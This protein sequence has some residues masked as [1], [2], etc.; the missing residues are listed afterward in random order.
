M[1]ARA[2]SPL[3]AASTVQPSRSGIM[4]SSVIAA[5]RAS[6]A[7]RRPSMPLAAVITENPCLTRKRSMR[8]RT[9]GS[10]SIT[11]TVRPALPD[12]S[13]AVRGRSADGAGSASARRRVRASAG[14]RMVKVEP[15]PGA[16]A[17]VMSPPIMRQR[18]RLIARPSPVPPYLRV[19]EASAWVN[20]SNSFAV[21]SGVMPMPVSETAMVTQSAPPSSGRRLTSTRIT[22]A[23]GELAGVAGEIEQRLAEPRRVGPDRAH[24]RRDSPPRSGCRSSP[25]AAGSS[26]PRPR[27]ADR[28]RPTRARAPARPLRSSRDRGCR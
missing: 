17:T 2:G 18:R 6:R 26:R 27:P 19:V 11:S 28:R 5:G 8:S 12:G 4:T 13:G 16:L 22:T 9:V 23:L 24:A 3:S 10:S 25:R 20:S 15:C 1:P 14:R 7:S 21:C